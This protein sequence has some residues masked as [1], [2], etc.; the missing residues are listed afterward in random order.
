M[1]KQ[2]ADRQVKVDE[3]VIA[4]VV[5]RMERSLTRVKEL[6]ELLD[7]RALAEGKTIT[8]PFIKK[9]LV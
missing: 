9:V 8:V 5:A 4:Y 2:F 7:A 6:V 3:E 1:R